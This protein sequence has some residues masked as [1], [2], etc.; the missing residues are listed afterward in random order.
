MPWNETP[1]AVEWMRG[2]GPL[3]ALRFGTMPYGVLPCARFATWR[4]FA[5]DDGATFEAFMAAG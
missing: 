3:P 5:S 1:S 2:R 4:P